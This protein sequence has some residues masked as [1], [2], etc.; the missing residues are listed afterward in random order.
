MSILFLYSLIL[1]GALLLMWGSYR[2]VRMKRLVLGRGVLLALTGLAVVAAAIP[3]AL[4]E[5]ATIVRDSTAGIEIGVPTVEFLGSDGAVAEASPGV[6]GS[7]S[8]WS[9]L[10]GIFLA[11]MALSFMKL[12]LTIGR[13]A[14]IIV[15]SDK[16]AGR[17]R[18]HDD[19]RLV[20]FTWG[21]WVVMSRSDYEANGPMLMAH[22]NAHLRG[23]HWLDLLMLNLLECLTWYCPATR[24]LRGE[25]LAAHE[26][27][28]DRA[29]LSSGFSAVDYQMLLISKAAGRRFAN[30]VTACINHSSL[31][32][33]IL[34][35]QNSSPES[36]SPRRALALI[37]AGLALF[38]IASTPALAARVSSVL[39]ATVV[40]QPAEVIV[41]PKDD[42]VE[43]DKTFGPVE[44]VAQFPGG[45]MAMLEFL[46]DNIRYP[47]S[48]QKAGK[49]GRVIV[50]F[51]IEKDGSI[52]D[53]KVLRSVDPALDAEAIRVVKTF[54]K[55]SPGKMSG[56]PVRTSY[57]LP[58]AFRLAADPKDSK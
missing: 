22:E 2:I 33:R 15:R 55:W 34:M 11:G 47:E 44:Q 57:T 9:L 51:I 37:P 16:A 31:K 24:L 39:P 40:Q 43:K 1:S 35:M 14:R 53:V 46:K 45:E 5:P 12:L 36:R 32:N 6:S 23:A 18:L 25:L 54:P 19:S 41:T 27:T 4:A 28:A 50:S 3:F 52:G 17:V 21:R 29:V 8:W 13:I 20:P 58:V 42:V 49:Q 10:G 26:C 7:F 30:S 38:A 48:A 56:T